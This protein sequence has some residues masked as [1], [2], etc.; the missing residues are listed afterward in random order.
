MFKVL[1]IVVVTL[2]TYSLSVKENGID[3]SKLACGYH[4]F[5][6]SKIGKVIAVSRDLLKE[7]P[8]HTKVRLINAGRF[9]GIYIVD[10]VMSKK[11]TNRIDVLVDSTLNDKYSFSGVQLER[12]Q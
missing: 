8:L 5:N 12:L 11:F 3:S 6:K 1:F 2:T 7:F 9:D 10:D 4:L